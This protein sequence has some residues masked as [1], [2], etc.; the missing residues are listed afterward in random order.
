MAQVKLLKIAADGVPLEFNSTSDDIT[1][2]SFTV[3]GGGP[4]LDG[5]GLDLNTQNLSDVGNITFTDPS[6][7][8]INQTA[9]NVVVDNLMA[10]ER[11]NVM[12]SAGA[13]LF[14]SISDSAGQVD[15]FKIPDIGA[16]PSATPAFST[17]AGYMVYN[18]VDKKFYI[19]DGSAWDDQSTV[20]S[21]NYIEDTYTAAVALTANDCVYISAADSVSKAKADAAGTSQAMGFAVASALITAPVS[22][23]KYGVLAGFTGL[24]AGARYYLSGATAGAITATTRVASGHTIVQVGYAKSATALDIQFQ[25]LGRRA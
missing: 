17:D 1:L 4:V 16:V 15:S 7:G 3:Q 6:T 12:T 14:G 11:D 23:R 8:T 20:S 13:I 24:T 21:A 2:N 22:I 10:K 18:S 25:S 5:T 19:W 9:G